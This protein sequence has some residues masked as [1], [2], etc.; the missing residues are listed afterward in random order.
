[1]TKKIVFS[2]SFMSLISLKKIVCVFFSFHGIISNAALIFLDFNIYSFVVNVMT[3]HW[4]MLPVSASELFN[5]VH[6]MSSD[7]S[8][9]GNGFIH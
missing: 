1:M 5:C 6:Q 8:C 4:V 3:G 2:V 7:R 9:D